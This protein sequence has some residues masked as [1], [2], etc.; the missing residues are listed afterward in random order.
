MTIRPGWQKLRYWGECWHWEVEGS[1]HSAPVT[2]QKRNAPKMSK[3]LILMSHPNQEH[4]HVHFLTDVLLASSYAD[5]WAMLRC[6]IS[7]KLCFCWIGSVH[8]P[9]NWADHLSS[10]VE[11]RPADPSLWSG[12]L[13]SECVHG[14]HQ[15][16]SAFTRRHSYCAFGS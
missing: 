14:V 6:Q 9:N 5:I 1:A 8:G 4:L 16:N 2:L 15:T 3:T 7:T 12:L 11:R 13:I 10:I